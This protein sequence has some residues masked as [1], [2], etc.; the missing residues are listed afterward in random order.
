[1]SKLGDRLAA[2]APKSAP[3]SILGHALAGSGAIVYRDVVIP[4]AGGDGVRAKLR[5][6]GYGEELDAVAALGEQMRAAQLENDWLSR[7]VIEAERA[8]QYLA[9]ACRDPADPS[10]PI[11][12]IEDWRS[13]AIT[14]VLLRLWIEYSDHVVG[15]D[16]QGA[17]LSQADADQIAAA[18]QKKSRDQL[19]SFGSALLASWITSMADRLWPS[20]TPTS[21][22][23][24]LPDTTI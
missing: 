22:A 23:G 20:P 1:M 7:D 4:V 8:R 9:R 18:A 12:T 21:S 5:C 13:P 15:Y 24:S 10:K 6:L 19:T 11:G 16:P 14:P 17:E 2:P 3:A